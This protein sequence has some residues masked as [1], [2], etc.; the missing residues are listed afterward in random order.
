MLV[1]SNGVEVVLEYEDVPRI[2]KLL[3]NVLDAVHD[4]GTPCPLRTQS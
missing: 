1:W 4:T 2:F 3:L